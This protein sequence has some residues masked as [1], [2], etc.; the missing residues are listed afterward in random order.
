ML[1]LEDIDPDA[2][3]S[4]ECIDNSFGD[5]SEASVDDTEEEVSSPELEHE[6]DLQS[7][8]P[9]D[10]GN[11]SDDVEGS[12]EEGE[13]LSEDPDDDEES[14]SPVKKKKVEKKK[15][16]FELVKEAESP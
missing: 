6:L 13:G 2:E 3:A 5:V 12:E 16:L 7:P 14:T 15:T 8:Q 1:K 4:D 9:N 11:V 10:N